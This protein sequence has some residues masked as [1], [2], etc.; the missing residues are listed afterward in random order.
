[1]APASRITLLVILLAASNIR[2]RGLNSEFNDDKTIRKMTNPL[3]LAATDT[4]MLWQKD[5]GSYK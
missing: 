2:G 1:M 4:E 3:G 5:D